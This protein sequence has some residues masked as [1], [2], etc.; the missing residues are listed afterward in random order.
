[1]ALGGVAETLGFRCGLFLRGGFDASYIIKCFLVLRQ[2]FALF[3]VRVLWMVGQNFGLQVE[4]H[5]PPTSCHPAHLA[6][7][8]K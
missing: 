8:T 4:K 3:S 2:G 7:G 1:M 6:E 5:T